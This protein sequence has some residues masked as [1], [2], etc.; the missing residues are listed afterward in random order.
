MI[1]QYY[2]PRRQLFA[3]YSKKNDLV[4]KTGYPSECSM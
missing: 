4:F 3:S 2:D 1:T